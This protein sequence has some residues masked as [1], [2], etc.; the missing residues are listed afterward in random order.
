MHRCPHTQ[1]H[2]AHA[3]PPSLCYHP[4][5]VRPSVR[6]SVSAARSAVP[7][8]L[9]RRGGGNP[10]STPHPSVPSQR[11]GAWPFGVAG[12]GM[13][14]GRAGG[15]CCLG[16]PPPARLPRF[17]APISRPQRRAGGK[18]FIRHAKLK[19]ALVRPHRLVLPSPLLAPSVCAAVWPLH[20]ARQARSEYGGRVCMADASI[21]PV[22][23][24]DDA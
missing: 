14:R 15:E 16:F 23:R 17:R 9:A 19:R 21:Y 4:P 7:P 3:C 22:P 2:T 6:P 20:M 10:A 5:A 13:C 11:C 18:P 24:I 8:P 1:P 12:S